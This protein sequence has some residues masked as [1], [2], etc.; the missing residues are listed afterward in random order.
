MSKERRRYFRI[1]DTVDLAFRILK[2][3][4]PDL[5]LSS[6][7]LDD[8]EM[9]KMVDSE[10]DTVLNTLW[11]SDPR[12]ARVMG[13]LN[14]K[15][16]LLTAASRPS[17][18]E[19]MA[20][21]DYNYPAL[22]VSLSA[23]GVAFDCEVELRV[24]DRLEVLLLLESV[25]SGLVLRGEVVNIEPRQ[26]EEQQVLFTCVEFDIETQQKEQLIQH[27]ARRQLKAIRSREHA[28]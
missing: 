5:K 28:V 16:N 10:L 2:P 15:I 18:Q 1:T 7:I 25:I 11:N 19:I 27:I 12:F 3:Q 8:S 23:S 20:Q 17:R 9:L 21:Y 26:V 13:L 14:Q 6:A 4:V 22:S 24:G